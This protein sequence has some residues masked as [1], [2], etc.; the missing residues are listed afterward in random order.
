MSDTA[1]EIAVTV[2]VEGPS[3]VAAVV[4][5]AARAGFDVRRCGVSVISMGG[6]TNIRRELRRVRRDRRHAAVAGL[7]DAGEVEVVQRAL[8]H[9][10]MPSSSRADMAAHGFFVCERDLEDEL[11][12]VLGVEWMERVLQEEGEL[13]AFRLFQQQPAQR[14]R[15]THEQLH[16]FSGTRSGRKIRLAAV[17]VSA[18]DTDESPEPLARLL[19]LVQ[20]HAK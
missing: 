8:R 14:A 11:L 17:M 16:R 18:L 2:L 12:R 9:E 3:D 15:S 5:L 7:C 6:V 20:R 1:A 4:A 19:E 13:T 10:G